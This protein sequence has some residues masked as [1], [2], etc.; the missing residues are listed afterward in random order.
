[1]RRLD[2]VLLA[3]DGD[4]P[5][6]SALSVMTRISQVQT[7]ADTGGRRSIRYVTWCT[8]NEHGFRRCDVVGRFKLSIDVLANSLCASHTDARNIIRELLFEIQIKKG[9]F[10]CPGDEAVFG[11]RVKRLMIA[12]RD[13]ARA[14]TVGLC[15]RNGKDSVALFGGTDMVIVN[16]LSRDAALYNSYLNSYEDEARDYY[17]RYANSIKNMHRHI[18]FWAHAATGGCPRGVDLQAS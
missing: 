4:D 12:A 5:P 9:S 17:S 2:V 11:D 7:A 16:R 18:A 10:L 14:D 6:N 1:M 3:V 13:D 15:W 8:K